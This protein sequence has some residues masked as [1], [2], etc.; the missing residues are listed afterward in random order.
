MATN[1]LEII[2]HSKRKF[3]FESSSLSGLL[4]FSGVPR[5]DEEKSNK[6]R[7]TGRLYGVFITN[8]S[9]KYKPW[10]DQLE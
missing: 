9:L 7:K 1:S 8:V 2:K 3:T 10:L 6:T 4:F 5:Y